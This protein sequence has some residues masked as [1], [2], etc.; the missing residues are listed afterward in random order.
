M[1]ALLLEEFGLRERD[2]KGRMELE[3]FASNA[4]GASARSVRRWRFEFF[5]NLGQ[6]NCYKRGNMDVLLSKKR[7]AERKQQSEPRET[8]A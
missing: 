6:F 3:E 2:S 4:I 8:R 1:I 7:S 5:S